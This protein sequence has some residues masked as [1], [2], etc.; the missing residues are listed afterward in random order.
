[1]C[2]T[3]IFSEVDFNYTEIRKNYQTQNIIGSLIKMASE[4]TQ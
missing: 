4:V 3:R 2:N 1:M